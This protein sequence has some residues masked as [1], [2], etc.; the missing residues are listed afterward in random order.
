MSQEAKIEIREEIAQECSIK[1]Y[2]RTIK[3]NIVVF[4]TAVI[5]AIR[6][7]GSAIGLVCAA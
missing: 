6:T 7:C 4:D 5:V 1:G 2:V 3:V